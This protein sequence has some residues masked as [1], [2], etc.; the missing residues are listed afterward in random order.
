MHAQFPQ[1]REFSAPISALYRG[2]YTVL[3]PMV[4]DSST[5]IA[6]TL[7]PNSLALMAHLELF[8]CLAP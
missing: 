7:R 6:Y 1:N 5:T 8:V 2:V 3:L 4:C